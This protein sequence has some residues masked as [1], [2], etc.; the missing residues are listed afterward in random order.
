[1]GGASC[2]EYD[3]VT[4]RKI[5]FPR[6]PRYGDL[7]VY[8]NTAGYQMDKNET[9]FHQIPLPVRVVLS[10]TESRFQWRLDEWP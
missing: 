4:W 1:V 3:M 10:Y 6:V 8:P 5:P 9:E 7:L 2:L